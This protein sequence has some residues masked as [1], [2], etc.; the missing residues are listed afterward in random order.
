M[1]IFGSYTFNAPVER[2]W[3]LLMDPNA[4]S[5]CIPGCDRFELIGEDRYNVTLTV[6][7]AAITGTYLAGVLIAQT[8][9]KTTID[10]GVHPLTYSMFV[11]LFFISIGLQTNARELGPRAAFTVALLVVAVVAKAV[12]CGVFARLFGFSTTQAVRVGVGM[13]PRG[14]VEL[15]IAGYGLANGII[16]SDVFSAA[17]TMVLAT[18]MVAPPL[19]RLAFPRHAFVPSMVEE[20]IAGPPEE[21]E[22][23]A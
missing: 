8:E 11:P 12:G 19:V 6:A 21:G 5:S 9:F 4:I 17:V 13:I 7:M 22:A 2:V 10:R 16:G 14:E 20:T 23:R 3:D 1:D 15:I 18:T